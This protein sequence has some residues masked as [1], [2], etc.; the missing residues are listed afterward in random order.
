MS[1]AEH[2]FSSI[3]AI[4]DDGDEA[5]ENDLRRMELID[6][7]IRAW[8]KRKMEE[9]AAMKKTEGNA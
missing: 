1:G 8:R 3:M 4:L 6:D 9:F 2:L 7:E 5:T